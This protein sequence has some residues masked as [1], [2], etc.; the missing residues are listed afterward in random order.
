MLCNYWTNETL[1]R[2]LTTSGS[3]A[4]IV[5]KSWMN[6]FL[7]YWHLIC[8]EHVHACRWLGGLAQPTQC[9]VFDGKSRPVLIVKDCAKMTGRHSAAVHKYLSQAFSPR[10]LLNLINLIKIYD[11]IFNMISCDRSYDRI[12]SYIQLAISVLLVLKN[13]FTWSL[14]LSVSGSRSGRLVQR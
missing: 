9:A 14:K 3:C 11:F 5:M 2:S 8:I 10:K 12:Q 1:T 13:P 7:E 4:R 6:K